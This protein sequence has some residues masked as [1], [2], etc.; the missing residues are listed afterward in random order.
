MDNTTYAR[1][2]VVVP[3]ELIARLEQNKSTVGAAAV[4][5]NNLDAEMTRILN[6]KQLGDNEK[7]K[8]YQ[9]VLQRH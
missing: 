1:K 6:D 8:L 7:C 2:M 5:N 9:Q 3:P 4:E